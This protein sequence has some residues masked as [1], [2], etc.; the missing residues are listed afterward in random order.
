M[1]HDPVESP[2]HD[3]VPLY[4][5]HIWY[6]TM[7]RWTTFFLIGA[8]DIGVLHAHSHSGP[9]SVCHAP[10]F[11]PSVPGT[12]VCDEQGDL[13][14]STLHG[15]RTNG[16]LV[17][18]SYLSTVLHLMYS[19]SMCMHIVYNPGSCN[20]KRIQTFYDGFH[21]PS[22]CS[23]IRSSRSPRSQEKLSAPGCS[24][25]PAECFVKRNTAE[26]YTGV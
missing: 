26:L 23:T 13:G 16:V 18:V 1:V 12:L 22:T 20:R 11:F 9:L 21:G 3:S 6:L 15:Q 5:W 10:R 25:Y 14:R 4:L 24:T 2:D 19:F 17:A 7:P 8:L